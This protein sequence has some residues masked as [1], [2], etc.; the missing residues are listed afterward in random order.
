MSSERRQKTIFQLTLIG[1]MAVTAL[2][3]TGCGGIFLLATLMLGSPA[4]T[5]YQSGYSGDYYQSPA[6]TEYASPADRW[7]S[8]DQ[9]S[10]RI[11][12]GTFDRSGQGND[13]IS[14]DGEVLTLPN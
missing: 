1:L 13:V 5:S 8:D 14:V 3:C 4:S 12:S 9:W 10:G 2:C 6:I 7:Q 11:S